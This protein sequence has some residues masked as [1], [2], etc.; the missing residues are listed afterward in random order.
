M[1][2]LKECHDLSPD[3]P[4]APIHLLLGGVSHKQ[5]DTRS[6]WSR[7]SSVMVLLDHSGLAYLHLNLISSLNIYGAYL[8][9]I[10]YELIRQSYSSCHAGTNPPQTAKPCMYGDSRKQW[11]VYHSDATMTVLSS[12]VDK[13]PIR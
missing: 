10:F 13:R 12:I 3:T 2:S 11:R 5:Q 9:L 7:S 6:L 1:T 8:R 4:H